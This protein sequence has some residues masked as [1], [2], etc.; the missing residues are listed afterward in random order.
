MA[1][2]L[3]FGNHHLLLQVLALGGGPHGLTGEAVGN[4]LALMLNMEDIAMAGDFFP[5][6]RLMACP[7]SAA[8]IGDRPRRGESSI[9]RI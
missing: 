7:Q 3:L 8:C 2:S 1:L 6:R 9:Y 4:A 5:K